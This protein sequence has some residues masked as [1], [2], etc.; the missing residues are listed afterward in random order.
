M[1]L[2]C[3]VLSGSCESGVASCVS[4]SVADTFCDSKQFSC[5]FIVSVLPFSNSLFFV[6]Y[7]DLK[8]V[9]LD[10]WSVK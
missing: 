5:S 10:F 8:K 3:S 2:F 4:V 9:M 1:G 7:R 6:S